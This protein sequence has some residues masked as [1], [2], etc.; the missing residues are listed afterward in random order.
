MKYNTFEA[1]E[2]SL[3]MYNFKN[4]LSPF[5]M[6]DPGEAVVLPRVPK[7]GSFYAIVILFS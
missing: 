2:N 7:I 6:G 5:E 4:S 1:V 3:K